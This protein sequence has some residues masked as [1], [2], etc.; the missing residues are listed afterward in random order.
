MNN[1]LVIHQNSAMS[2]NG[3]IASLSMEVI[4]RL[5]NTSIELDQE[6]IDRIIDNFTVKLIS[7]GY[8]MQQAYTIINAGLKGYEKLLKKQTDGI[9]NIHRPAANGVA[10]RNRKKL[11]SK[12]SWFKKKKD[13]NKNEAPAE[14]SSENYRP[15]NKK[16]GKKPNTKEIRTTTV[17]FVEQ[18]PGGEL[19]NIFREKE[20]EL[21]LITGF[22][23]KIVERNGTRANQLLHKPNPWSNARCQNAKCY[24]CE[25]GDISDCS[26][27]NLV[28]ISSCI[29]CR[30]AEKPMYYVGETS[31][32][33]RERGAEHLDD[34]LKG[35][36]ESHM[37]K[38]LDEVHPGQQ[39]AS[40]EFR[41]HSTFQKALT[42]QITEAVLIRRAGEAT[43][44]S[45]GV[46]NRCALPRL[47]VECGKS[48]KQDEGSKN[49]NIDWVERKKTA[50]RTEKVE[51][52]K[53]TKKI[54]L[55]KEVTGGRAPRYEGIQKRKRTETK[56]P[57][58]LEVEKF[59]NQCKKFRPNF[60]PADEYELEEIRKT[61][62]SLEVV[63]S[64]E[65]HSIISIQNLIQKPKSQTLFPIFN[66]IARSNPTQNKVKSIPKR[67]PSKEK[68]LNGSGGGK[69][70]IRVY[71]NAQKAD[72]STAQ[73]PEVREI[74]GISSNSSQIT[75]INL[76]D[77]G[78]ESEPEFR[79]SDLKGGGKCS[80]LSTSA[81][82]VL[83]SSDQDLSLKD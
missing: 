30:K 77:R 1:K 64:Q 36:E 74:K 4:R 40:F 71:F 53:Q 58:S 48:K 12:S 41:V 17:L 67:K 15:R 60:D 24:P 18:T 42:R 65:N 26:K 22:R 73:G 21:S 75:A 3:K 6:R 72:H 66:K 19:A 28:Y 9:M 44:N 62:S 29:P 20:K 8:G 34:Y 83:E 52:K 51:I 56:T 5:K 33:S 78:G 59:N 38:H 55:D 31:R 63:V 11:T 39:Q 27:R 25:N 43:L 37:V 68:A 70:D 82:H 10:S 81:L 47:V 46:Y 49:T 50:K 16:S 35:K 76:E 7:S 45:K 80:L 69:V 61:K 23:V 54:K 2:E 14:K 57:G 13:Q 79:D 32:T